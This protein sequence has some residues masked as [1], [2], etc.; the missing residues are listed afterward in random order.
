MMQ[1][2]FILDSAR[3]PIAPRG[4]AL[5]NLS[6]KSMGAALLEE[7]LA[8]SGLTASDIHG[9]TLGNALAAGGNPARL[10]ALA[11]GL[12]QAIPA[13]TI[14]TQ[15]CSGL[16]AIA[17]SAERLAQS[18]QP[19]CWIAG[20]MESASTAPLRA[21]RGHDG[22][23]N[24]FDEA[25][26]S[27]FSDRNPTVE[28]SVLSLENWLHRTQSIARE[29][30]WH[31][32]VRSH[33]LAEDSPNADRIQVS[34]EVGGSLNHDPHLRRLTLRACARAEGVE[35]GG[36]A[37][38][39]AKATK[40]S[41]GQHQSHQ[42]GGSSNAP[43]VSYRLNPALVA[44]LADGSAASILVNE[45]WRQGNGAGTVSGSMMSGSMT[46]IIASTQVGGD[47]A[48]PAL[49]VD[50]LLP[51]LERILSRSLHGD[52]SAPGLAI[53]LMESFTAQAIAN[54]I[55]LEAALSRWKIPF[56]INSHGGLLALGHPI[57]AS[58]AVLV[59]RLVHRLH[60]GQLG[61]ALIPS[62][63]GLAS[64]LLMRREWSAS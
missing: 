2:V 8:R 27:P 37:A 24:F 6:L 25:E 57:G 15:C 21:R 12:P 1:R 31:Y 41:I 22:S 35:G 9:A 42:V 49:A 3:T 43:K 55:V 11:A 44:P 62:A 40:A 17:M 64:A 16:D 46:E 36:T 33:R 52:A 30:H 13:Q 45:S 56:E 63:G 32:A 18:D 54:R 60:P 10:V 26:F 23:L 58:G 20:G 48:W 38:T 7:L 14:D 47:P 34:L 51:W 61:L 4:G 53:E 59:S 50:S 29:E 19:L 39:G 5:R 28:E